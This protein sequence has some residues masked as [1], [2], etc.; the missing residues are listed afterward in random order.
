MILMTDK[1][2]CAH[3][4]RN[5]G[6]LRPNSVLSKDLWKTREPQPGDCAGKNHFRHKG[7][8]LVS[9]ADKLCYLGQVI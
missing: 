8:E 6:P 3:I 5:L 7:L 2:Y 9:N 4:R 1:K